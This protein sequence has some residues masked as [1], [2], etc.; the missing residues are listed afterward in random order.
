[1]NYRS[2]GQAA[3]EFLTTISWGILIVIIMLGILAFAGVLNPDKLIPDQCRL[4]EG[5]YCKSYKATTEGVEFIIQNSYGKDITIT[6]VDLENI[7]NCN[8]SINISIKNN[9]ETQFNISCDLSNSKRLKSDLIIRYNEP[10]GLSGLSNQGALI[11]SVPDATDNITIASE[12]ELVAAE[13][14]NSDV[15]SKLSVIDQNF[16]HVEGN[17]ILILKFNKSL[18]DKDVIQVYTKCH[19]TSIIAIKTNDN[20]F[21]SA[22]CAE[23]EVW[24][25]LNLV[26]NTRLESDEWI[27]VATEAL[28]YDFV[29]ATVN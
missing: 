15:T 18:S 16:L 25:R 27:M 22:K 3:T 6:E 9:E 17:E 13:K 4:G 26:L 1:M 29:S 28:D 5:L 19:H 11:V 23:E 10:N 12:S 14:Y 2:R 24:M 7:P 20:T 8:P 21:A